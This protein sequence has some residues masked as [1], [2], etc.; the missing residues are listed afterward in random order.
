MTIGRIDSFLIM[1][2]IFCF[3]GF[4]VFVSVAGIH[5]IYENVNSHKVCD[6]QETVKSVGGCN[7]WGECGVTYR[8][9]RLGRE[10]F[11]SIDSVYC[12]QSH[13]EKNKK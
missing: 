10:S 2:I 3:Y 8:S 12:L 6:Q 13:L 1:L 9:G 5:M 11:P 7:I 4:L